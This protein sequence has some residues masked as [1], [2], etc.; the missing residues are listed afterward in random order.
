[1][2]L[3]N[4]G[5]RIRGGQ[6]TL[7]GGM[8]HAVPSSQVMTF[9]LILLVVHVILASL[10]WT[11]VITFASTEERNLVAS[12]LTIVSFFLIV[13]LLYVSTSHDA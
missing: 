3:S 10:M 13:Y 4:M 12:A 9:I 8:L 5:C 2:E 1:M 7:K 6:R 11:N